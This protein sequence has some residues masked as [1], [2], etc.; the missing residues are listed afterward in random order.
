[1]EA[2]A[3]VSLAG[4]ILQFVGTVTR[5]ISSSRQI[6]DLGNSE[7]NIELEMLTRELKQLIVRVTPPPTKSDL[8]LSVEDQSLR[9]LAC[10]CT[11]VAEELLGVLRSLAVSERPGVF[12]SFY[13]ALRSEWNKE[14]VEDLQARVDRI[15]RAIDS[16]L[17]VYDRRRVLDRLDR[18]VEENRRLDAH[19]AG[20]IH[21]LRR[22]F[23]H[24]FNRLA[25]NSWSRDSRTKT[26]TST[27]L[28]GAASEGLQYSAEQ[29]ILEHLRFH[30]LEER[31]AS[32]ATPHADTFGWLFGRPSQQSP[33]N[34]ERWLRSEDGDLYWISGKPGSGKSTLM[35]HLGAHP[36]TTAGLD[37][38][39]CGQHLVRADYFFW[40]AG[41]GAYRNS[42]QELL[43]SILY[44]ILR[45]HPELL[46]KVY[47]N[48]L[49]ISE[50]TAGPHDLQSSPTILNMILTKEALLNA[51]HKIYVNLI[52]SEARFCFFIDGLDEYHGQTAE[53]IELIGLLRALPNVK[54]CVSSRP[55][56][57]FE[58]AFGHDGATKL[59]LHDYNQPD[60]AAYVRAT[61]AHDANFQ[62]LEDKET[63]GAAL[64]QEIVDAANGV[65]LW[66]Y[67]VTRSFQ[68]GLTNGDR[69]ADLRRR[70]R[71]IPTNLPEYYERI[72][73]SDVSPF[74]RAQCAQFFATALEW[75]GRPSLIA[76]WFIG[77]VDEDSEYPFKLDAQPLTLDQVEKRLQDMRKR[78]NARCKG[79]LEV[80]NVDENTGHGRQPFHRFFNQT[81]R[82]LHRSVRDFLLR[83]ETQGILQSWTALDFNPHE[84]ICKALLA[85]IKTAPEG[86]LYSG[87]G[88][89]IFKLHAVMTMHV[90]VLLSEP[91][92]FNYHI[93]YRALPT[94]AN[95]DND[96]KHSI[97][98]NF[99]S[100]SNATPGPQSLCSKSKT[101]DEQRAPQVPPNHVVVRQTASTRQQMKILVK[102]WFSRPSTSSSNT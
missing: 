17:A 34:F 1:M 50:T 55:W 82:F 9:A 74:Y 90:E 22:Q 10:H 88:G 4:N 18:L 48:L 72:M 8:L 70:L 91:R 45:Q 12:E 47:P 31:A 66:V 5:L 67:L 27:F 87:G 41:S 32:I 78:L 14:R 21:E 86:P 98:R 23:E 25:D 93:K 51:L 40:S 92:C 39:A 63:Q 62:E 76:F 96:Q 3:A 73:V 100:A 46:C 60:I 30:A 24:Q 102:R 52:G 26:E 77:E 83:P 42:Q 85:Q 53:I 65:F 11:A 81:V 54:L 35:K 64:I 101:G 57:E 7:T 15:S 37:V 99:E 29:I 75:R 6:A 71:A 20:E 95:T 97:A 61:F 36:L 94:T 89:P 84:M 58:Q 28:L 13:Q 2:L 16:H 43:R 68:D 69:L 44:Q 59:Y 33:A 79:L 49:G 19:R 38:W 80:Q 56:N